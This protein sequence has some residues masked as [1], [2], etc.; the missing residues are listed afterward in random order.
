MNTMLATA[1]AS[2]RKAAQDLGY[3]DK[4]IDEF[5]K[6]EKEHAFTVMSGGNA[7]PAYRVQ[8]NS[9]LGPYKGGIRFHHGV[10]KDEVQALATL[11]SVKTAAVGLPLGGGKGGI[12]VNPKQLSETE[13][14]EI[15]RDYARQLAPHIGSD[16][17]IPAPDVNTNA[18]IMD[19]MVAEL[20]KVKE[21]KD[22]GSFT[23][24]SIPSGGSEG[25]QAATGYG[26]V[27]VLIEYLKKH[28]MLD[29]PL[30]V[31]VQ[32]FGNAG[33]F[34]ARKLHDEHPNLKLVAIA[35]SKHTWVQPKGIDVTS[36]SVAT[37]RPED[38][39]DLHDV[40]PLPSSAIL[41]EKVDILA[42]AALE[43]AVNA[44]NAA[45]VQA[46]L[47]LEL[48]N[49]PVTQEAE[50]VLLEKNVTILP[51][52]VVNAGGVVV[53]YLEWQQNLDDQHWTEEE[54]HQKMDDMLVKA[55][56]DM[57]RRAEEKKVSHKQAAFEIALERLLG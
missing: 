3:D 17:D 23:G 49:G 11:M 18:Q 13:L 4:A 53:S 47:I 25:R 22:P 31:A 9:K 16:K 19:W 10:T 40:E 45:D 39:T 44:D 27:V 21:Q 32:G 7:Y 35:N 43:D 33:Y 46:T 52:V 41:S 57:L 50:Q 26:A 51:D 29:K 55:T 14:E 48:A 34:F 30:T 8:H 2:I 24:K 36:C 38:L 20:E 54:V 37:P 5:L 12:V 15:A 28:G 6:P 56:N 1:Q 42:L